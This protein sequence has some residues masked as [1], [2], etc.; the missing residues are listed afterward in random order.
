[1]ALK[2][3]SSDSVDFLDECEYYGEK[4]MNKLTKTSSNSMDC[5]QSR[6]DSYFSS[7]SPETSSISPSYPCSPQ[8]SYASSESSSSSSS[9]MSL[10]I[11]SDSVIT[12]YSNPFYTPVSKELVSCQALDSIPLSIYSIEPKFLPFN[13]NGLNLGGHNDELMNSE[14]ALKYFWF[15]VHKY[16]Y[17]FQQRLVESHSNN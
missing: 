2:R 8:S 12:P 13:L 5:T 15:A 16:Y 10:Q 14:A 3:K 1:M 6:R 17:M 7:K 9:S 4:R 11:L